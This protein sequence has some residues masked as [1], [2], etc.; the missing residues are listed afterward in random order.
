MDAWAL[1]RTSSNLQC[2]DAVNE[3]GDDDA[4]QQSF[5][6]V[7]ALTSRLLCGAYIRRGCNTLR[8]LAIV[9]KEH[10]HTEDEKQ[11]S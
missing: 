9:N 2:F 1:S 8:S 4:L 10:P 11:A 5:E 6:D 3:W 7:V